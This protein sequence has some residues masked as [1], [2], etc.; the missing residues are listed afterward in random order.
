[1][2]GGTGG[3]RFLVVEP[4]AAIEVLLPKVL[5]LLAEEIVVVETAEAAL[6]QLEGADWDLLISGIWLPGMDGLSLASRAR[7]AYPDL[8]ILVMTADLRA[9]QTHDPKLYGIDLFLPKPFEPTA[10]LNAIE[11][12]LKERLRHVAGA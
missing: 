11:G 2:A 7:A 8:A 6:T 3:L 4:D 10:L 5:G 12:V 1:M 9:I